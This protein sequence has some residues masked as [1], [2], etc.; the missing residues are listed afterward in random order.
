MLSLVI[1]ISVILTTG[2]LVSGASVGASVTTAVGA[3]V[4]SSPPSSASADACATATGCGVTAATFT[5]CTSNKLF[6]SATAC[7]G[8]GAATSTVLTASGSTLSTNVCT[9]CV[10][11]NGKFNVS[12]RSKRYWLSIFV[13][14]SASV[15]RSSNSF[16][17]RSPV[18]FFSSWVAA[19]GSTP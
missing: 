13:V 2:S 6:C 14:F 19:K 10:C 9:A 3:C 11:T 7:V 15:S 18:S 5:V 8:N 4:A 17:L 12:A 1:V 16:F